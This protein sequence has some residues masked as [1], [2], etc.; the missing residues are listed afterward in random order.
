MIWNAIFYLLSECTISVDE[1]SNFAILKLPFP[2]ISPVH[3][4]ATST[5]SHIFTGTT[6]PKKGTEG[7]H[8]IQDV[9]HFVLCLSLLS[10]V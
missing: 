6:F 3:A 5:R 7:F 9:G 1:N 10:S 4:V 8:K 2:D